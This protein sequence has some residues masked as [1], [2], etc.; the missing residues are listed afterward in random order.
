MSA[1]EVAIHCLHLRHDTVCNTDALS[2][3]ERERA[4]AFHSVQS[5]KLFIAGRQ[6]CRSVIARM[7]GQTESSVHIAINSTGKPYLPDHDIRFS[8][9]HNANCVLLATSRH[10][11]IGIDLEVFRNDHRDDLEAAASLVLSDVELRA[12][13]QLDEAERH[14]A[15]LSAW[16]RR[17]AALKCWGQGFLVDPKDMRIQ[18]DEYGSHMTKRTGGARTTIEGGQFSDVYGNRYFWAL[19]QACSNGIDGSRLHWNLSHLPP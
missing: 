3:D 10:V 12:I 15:L 1:G 9:S 4:A 2:M 8:L 18:S 5:R 13:L 14:D 11:N 16:V 17:E 6:L 19:A 7:T